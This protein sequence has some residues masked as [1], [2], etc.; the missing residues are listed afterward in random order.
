MG[1]SPCCEKA[2][3]N[4]GAWTK[5]ED[6][7]LINYIRSHG[8]GCWRSL[9]KA[10]GLL[11]CGKSCRLRWINYLRPDLKRGN[12]TDEEDD[13]I[14]KLHSL[15]GNKWSLIAGRLPGRTDNEI[16]NYWN[17]HIKRKLISRG[18]DP[19]THRSVN[20]AATAAAGT[21]NIAATTCLD[22]RH[23]VTPPSTNDPDTKNIL[24]TPT[25]DNSS[26]IDNTKCSSSTTEESQPPAPLPPPPPAAAAEGSTGLALD[27]ELSIG[28]PSQSKYTRSGSFNF[29]WAESKSFNDFLRPAAAAI[30]AE[31][32]PTAVKLV[33]RAMC[34]CRQMGLQKGQL[35]SNCQSYNGVY[36]YC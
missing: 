21:T 16:K 1:R 17:T 27:L 3:T 13:I 23:S 9:P 28:L 20:A 10:A 7:R 8:E 15:L 30:V 26:S 29:S 22:F 32:P 34:L 31:A 24:C 5:E 35:C 14:I 4:K 12:F 6:Q 2:H 18:I 19:H 25:T 33:A 36:R 11:R